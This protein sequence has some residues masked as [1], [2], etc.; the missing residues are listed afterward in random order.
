[1]KIL[2]FNFFIL[3]FSGIAFSQSLFFN[4]LDNSIWWSTLP[5][6][7]SVI[8]SSKE[9]GLNKLNSQ[10][11]LLENGTIWSFKNDSLRISQY[12][13]LQKR[14]LLIASYK[15]EVEAAKNLIIVLQDK[16]RMSFS[17]GITSI[18]NYVLLTRI[19]KKCL[20]AQDS[21]VLFQ[22]KA[23]MFSN[24]YVFFSNGTFRHEYL[25]D[26]LQMWYGTGTYL[27]KGM[28]RILQFGSAELI[29]ETSFLIHYEANFQRKLKKFGKKFKSRDYYH[30]TRKKR[31][32]FS[33]RNT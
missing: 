4:N 6:N 14:E 7:D 31:V 3:A 11:E 18:G 30:T 22:E 27:D 29:D 16:T 17:V 13:A 19:K 28:T 2:T 10:E 32:T 21:L 33:P 15:T 8:R 1:M 24:K 5:I 23:S 12:D 25:T 9:I 20:L 26:D